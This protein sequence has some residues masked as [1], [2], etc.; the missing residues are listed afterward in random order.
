MK[1]RVTEA[2]AE[3]VHL[4][5][6]LTQER[7]AFERRRTA[8]ISGDDQVAALHQALAEARDNI[9]EARHELLQQ[10]RLNS[11]ATSTLSNLRTLHQA[12][13]QRRDTLAE[14]AAL[15]HAEI[16]EFHANMPNFEESLIQVQQAL[17]QVEN[18]ADNLIRSREQLVTERSQSQQSLAELREHRSAGCTT[19]RAGR[20]RRSPGRLWNRCSRNLAAS[21]RSRLGTMESDL[22]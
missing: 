1:Q 3:E 17:L 8:M 22:R 13:E 15:L 6:V 10:V 14:Q 11:E 9:E 16:A 19:R 2:I 12:A 4:N 20:S 21:R 18:D 5:S 7:A